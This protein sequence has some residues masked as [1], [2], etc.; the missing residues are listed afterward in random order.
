M[1]WQCDNKDLIN[2]SMKTFKQYLSE[3]L[4][5]SKKRGSF[6][7]LPSFQH[8]TG[9][10]HTKNQFPDTITGTHYI[11]RDVSKIAKSRF[12]RKRLP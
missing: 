1:E 5:R 9:D 4:I 6:R 3:A 11:G 7:V 2:N 10:I 8:T 12:R